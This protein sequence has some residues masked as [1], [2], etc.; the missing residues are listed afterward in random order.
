M[1][2]ATRA[3]LGLFTLVAL[4]ITGWSFRWF[5]API[6]GQVGAR[7]RI[8]GATHR[9]EA[10][11]HFFDL[12]ASIQTKEGTITAQLA[13]TDNADRIQQNVAALQSRRLADI[14]Q[15]NAD[16][17]KSYTVGQFRDSNLPYNIAPQPFDGSNRTSCTD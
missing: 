8:Q 9:I 11:E 14:N 13:R 15:Y 1:K 5:A 17:S 12:C 3:I 7:E 6:E 16:A 4:V 10:Y 2:T